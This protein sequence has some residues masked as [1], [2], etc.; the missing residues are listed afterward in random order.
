MATSRNYRDRKLCTLISRKIGDVASTLGHVKIMNFCGTHEHT[1]TYYG[2]RSL[3]PEN[4]ELIPGPGCPVCV[5]DTAD[6]MEAVKL[7][8]AENTVVATFGDIVR[9]PAGDLSLWK[10]RARG[11]RVRV[12]YSPEDALKMARETDK[13]VVFFAVGFETTAPAI[14]ATLTLNP[15]SN[16][17]MLTSV[18]LTPPVMKALL[19]MG[20]VKIDG[21]IAPGHVSTIIGYNSWR[22]VAERGIPVVTAGFEPADVLM[23]ILMIIR[24]IAEGK[25]RNVNEYVRSVTPEGN[26]KAKR[27]MYQIFKV[28]DARWRGIGVVKDS[29]LYLKDEYSS[30]DARLQFDIDIG[31]PP[32]NP[33][34][35][36]CHKI[37][38]GSAYPTDC[39]LF[40]KTCT[41]SRP[42]GPCMVS[43]EG[44]CNIWFKYG[45][46]APLASPSI[47]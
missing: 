5:A 30:Y 42:Y 36:L 32:G 38:M 10:A 14:A 17:Y 7:S 11:G 41:P 15:P 21:V 22:F 20:E 2:I 27:L 19:D 18:R 31:E 29:G 4:V 3:V 13:N 26:V 46:Q 24:Q 25:P 40:G 33:P 45:L 37:V 16:Y 23:A 9:V 8:M 43:A 28:E 1:I 39:K 12:I 44:A 34:G 35:C 47:A 6:I